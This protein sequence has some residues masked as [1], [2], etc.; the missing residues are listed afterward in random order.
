M[1]CRDAIAGGDHDVIEIIGDTL[2]SVR[3]L[4]VQ[5]VET[6]NPRIVGFKM[7]VHMFTF[8]LT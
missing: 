3:V 6:G 8:S 5:D 7:F 4:D 1:L 2:A